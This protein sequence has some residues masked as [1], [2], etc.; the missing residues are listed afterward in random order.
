MCAIWSPCNFAESTDSNRMECQS[1]ANNRQSERKNE[2]RLLLCADLRIGILNILYGRR[3]FS[4]LK[5]TKQNQNRNIVMNKMKFK[6]KSCLQF[7]LNFDQ[8]YS[9]FDFFSLFLPFSIQFDINIKEIDENFLFISSIS[10]QKY[11]HK[12]VYIVCL[13]CSEPLPRC[14]K[15]KFLL[16]PIKKFL[17]NQPLWN[18]HHTAYRKAY[19]FI[20]ILCS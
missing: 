9:N 14:Y 6:P 15:C 1:N 18:S 20:S 13:G 5:E 12:C 7:C 16:W 4:S 17:M 11:E 3:V 10:S 2:T 8:N 19:A